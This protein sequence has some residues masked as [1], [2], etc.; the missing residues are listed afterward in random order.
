MTTEKDRNGLPRRELCRAAE[1]LWRVAPVRDDSGRLLADFM[2]V[3]PRMRSRGPVFAEHA[4]HAVR[5]AC[6]RFDGKIRFAELN[7]TTGVIWVSVAAEPG[8]CAQVASAIRLQ[9][10]EALLVGGQLGAVSGVP[11]RLS[12][13]RRLLRLV[14]GIRRHV[15]RRL[16]PCRPGNAAR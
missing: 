2:L 9:L 3:V 13:K 6:E 12:G 7:K 1:P 8:L 15:A 10:P 16:L 4:V 5:R 14:T 11:E